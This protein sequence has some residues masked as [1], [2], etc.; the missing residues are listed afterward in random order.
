ME[1]KYFVIL[2]SIVSLLLLYVLSTFSNP[3]E[4]D[5]ANIEDYEDKYV[6]VE[7]VVIEHHLTEYGSQ[8]IEIRDQKEN[9]NTGVTVF[10]EE[11]TTIEPTRIAAPTNVTTYPAKRVGNRL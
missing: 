1:L 3:V 4:I 7:G 6:L 8:L 10:V 5:L 2:L 9:N 11:E